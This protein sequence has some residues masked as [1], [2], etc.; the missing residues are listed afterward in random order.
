[1]RL[2]P[3]CSVARSGT[4]RCQR[5][6]C[7][8]T[9]AWAEEAPYDHER[10][11]AIVP[12]NSADLD[13]L[14]LDRPLAFTSKMAA[15][16]PFIGSM[17]GSPRR[18]PPMPRAT[19]CSRWRKSSTSKTRPKAPERRFRR[20]R[21]SSADRPSGR[22]TSRS[23]KLYWNKTLKRRVLLAGRWTPYSRPLASAS[24]LGP[25]PPPR[26][27]KTSCSDRK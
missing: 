10:Q 27:R 11:D 7:D 18:L 16:A 4:T 26:F 12:G 19:F 6:D 14:K 15:S 24:N 25:P 1:L 23:R 20:S 22:I 9:D 5:P 21:G 17:T 3:A 2:A 13:L 8:P